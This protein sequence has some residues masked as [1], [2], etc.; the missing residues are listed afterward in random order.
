MYVELVDGCNV[1]YFKTWNACD[2][3]RYVEMLVHLNLIS[4]MG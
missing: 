2:I 4:C 3:A 1:L